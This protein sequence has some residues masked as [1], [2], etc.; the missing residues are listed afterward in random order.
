MRTTRL[1]PD[2]PPL[3]VIALGTPLFGSTISEDEAFAQL[4]AYAAA[5][6]NLLDSAHVYAAWLPGGTGQSERTIGRWLRRSGLASGVTIATKGG[7]PALTSMD[8]HR[9]QPA[10]IAQD[11]NESL[12]RLQCTQVGIYLLHRDAEEVPV[13]ELLTALEEQ[14]RAGKIV[15]YGASNW[16]VARLAEAAVWA[17]RN[18]IRGFSLD[19]PGWSLA[20]RSS[21]AP[22]VPGCRYGDAELLAWH[23]RSGMGTM[24]YSSQANGWF[25]KDVPAYDT[26]ANRVRRSI[27]ERIAARHGCSPTQAAV[28]WLTSKAFPAVA[29]VGPRTAEQLADS[30]QAGALRLSQEECTELEAGA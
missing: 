21:T 29:V 9:L 11:L 30:I 6:G 20:E 28:A 27:A 18:H 17:Q 8:V 1:H 5:G 22:V 13:G 4:D 24:A 2:L 3:S 12:E 10:A 15:A 25:A 26:P 19:Q 14:R 7:H 23:R 16:S